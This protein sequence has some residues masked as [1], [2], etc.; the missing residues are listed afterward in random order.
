MLAEVP[1]ER[2]DADAERCGHTAIV[3]S[4]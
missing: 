3:R 4:A 2:E 1:L